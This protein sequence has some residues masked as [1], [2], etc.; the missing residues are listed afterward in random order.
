MN[1]LLVIRISAF[2]NFTAFGSKQHS[3]RKDLYNLATMNG[4]PWMGFKIYLY[5]NILKIK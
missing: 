3:N 1:L 4:F 2:I 5:L